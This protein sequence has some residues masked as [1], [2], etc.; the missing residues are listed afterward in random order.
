M[1]CWLSRSTDWR[2]SSSHTLAFGR[3]DYR[4]WGYGHRNQTDSFVGFCSFHHTLV[5]TVSVFSASCW[6]IFIENRVAGRVQTGCCANGILLIDFS[7]G[8]LCK[9]FVLAICF[10]LLISFRFVIF[11]VCLFSPVVRL[12]YAFRYRNDHAVCWPTVIMTIWSDSLGH[13]VVCV[14]TMIFFSF[15][16]FIFFHFWCLFALNSRFRCR[17][18]VVFVQSNEYF[19]M[20]VLI[21]VDVSRC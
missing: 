13:S 16:F 14:A 21:R 12:T 15:C 18:V 5:A 19:E 11:T 2:T 20:I 1:P 17:F 7:V 4:K 10:L 3:D 6:E 8:S 9:R